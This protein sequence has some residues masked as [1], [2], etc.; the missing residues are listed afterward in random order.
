MP[1]P[2]L[3][4]VSIRTPWAVPALDWQCISRLRPGECSHSLIQ[5]TL[6]GWVDREHYRANDR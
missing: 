6:A 2:R 4:L 1:L 3:L 5:R